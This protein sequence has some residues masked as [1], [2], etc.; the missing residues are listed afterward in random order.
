MQGW[1]DGGIIAAGP[2][3]IRWIGSPLAVIIKNSRICSERTKL[4]GDAGMLR[5]RSIATLVTTAFVLAGCNHLGGA[6]FGGLLGPGGFSHASKNCKVAF[7]LK[8][9]I[10]E[11][12][13]TSPSNSF[14]I[15]DNLEAFVNIV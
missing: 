5:A 9:N 7:G 13:Y 12:T 6:G 14:S 8:G 2:N 1:R 4:L 11:T 3:A 10:R 15:K